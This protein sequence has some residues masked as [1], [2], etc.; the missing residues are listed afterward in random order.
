LISCGPDPSPGDLHFIQGYW[1]IRKVTFSDGVE[2]AY[3]ANAAIEYFNWDG[4]TGYRKKMQPTVDGKYLTSDD[5]LP[6]EISWREGVLFL[7]FQGGD[8]QWEEEVLELD[9]L[10]LTTRHSNGILYSYSR[11]EP[12]SLKTK[13]GEEAGKPIP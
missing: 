11:Y 9:S 6:M 3:T 13:H 4:T 2:K 8:S 7:Q 1:E 5:A 10:K 12:F